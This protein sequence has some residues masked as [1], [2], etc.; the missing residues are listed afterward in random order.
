ME[1]RDLRNIG[2]IVGKLPQDLILLIKE[3]LEEIQSDF[4]S[5]IPNNKNLV[6]HIKQEYNMPRAREYLKSYLFEMVQLHIKAYDPLEKIGISRRKPPNNKKSPL[7]IEVGGIWAN[8]QKKYEFNPIHDHGGMYSFV[9][10]IQIPYFKAIEEKMS[11]GALANSNKSGM[12]E[13]VYTDILGNVVCESFPT[14]NSMESFIVLFPAR[15][16]HTVYPFFSSD[17]YRI[18]VSGNLYIEHKEE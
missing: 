4:S 6:G 12:F 8:F 18:S 3:E 11:P 1:A 2:I 10:W 5:A 13:F 14:D 9:T 7:V 17:N 15:L 16:N